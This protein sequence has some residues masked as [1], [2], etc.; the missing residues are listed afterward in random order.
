MIN[1]H[2][3]RVR[4]AVAGL[5]EQHEFMKKQQES[6]HLPVGFEMHRAQ[7]RS[8]VVTVVALIEDAKKLLEEIDASR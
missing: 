4:E 7:L 8:D 6:G 3:S 5:R 1:S 2:V